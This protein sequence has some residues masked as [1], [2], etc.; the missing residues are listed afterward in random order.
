MAIQKNNKKESSKNEA[1]AYTVKVERVKEI[2]GKAD[3]YRFNLL[4]NGVFINGVKYITYSD[5]N[6][7]PASFIGF[8]NYKGTDGKYY[9]ICYFPVNDPEYKAVYE[10]IEKQIGEALDSAGES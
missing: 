1:R 10:D 2:A 5:Q 3:S 7:Q 6:G 9:N 8:P 4:V